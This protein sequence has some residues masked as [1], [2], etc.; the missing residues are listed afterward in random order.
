MKNEQFPTQD[1]CDSEAPDEFAVWAMV[2]IPGM[3]GAGLPFPVTY[4]RMVSQRLWDAGFRHHPELQ[5]IKYK[6]PSMDDP[7][8]LTN[9]GS[10][11]PV[12]EPVEDVSL[13]DY[14]EGLPLGERQ[15]IAKHLGLS[16]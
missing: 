12:D 10:W 3:K 13:K 5:T 11:V 15:A 16:D 8:W 1:N 7:H 9:P 4:L 14:I 6:R 2:G